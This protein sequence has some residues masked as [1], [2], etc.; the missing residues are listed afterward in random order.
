MLLESD[1][2]ERWRSQNPSG[3]DANR[4]NAVAFA[5]NTLIAAGQLADGNDSV[6]QVIG[7]TDVGA[8]AWRRVFRGSSESGEGAAAAVALDQQRSAIFVAG[9]VANDP[10]GPDMFAAGLN[11]DGD[12]LPEVPLLASR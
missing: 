1:G 2:R 9:V 6:F 11:F 12:D 8:E 7:F 5:G 4:T 3:F 10:T